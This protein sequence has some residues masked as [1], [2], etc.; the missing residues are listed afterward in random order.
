MVLAGA[1]GWS[2]TEMG[3]RD[4]GE[5]LKGRVRLARFARALL[6]PHKRFARVIISVLIPY[7]TWR[8]MDAVQQNGCE[9]FSS[10]CGGNASSCKVSNRLP[11]ER[12]FLTCNEKA[13]SK[14]M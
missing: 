7:R 4:W 8:K 11:K 1:V 14:M 2:E 12:Q 13:E 5:T 10:Y 6:H 9:Y 3:E